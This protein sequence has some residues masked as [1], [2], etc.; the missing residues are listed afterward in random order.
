[1]VIGEII[2]TNISEA[3]KLNAELRSQKLTEVNNE[4]KKIED[5]S[6]EFTMIVNN[7]QENVLKL[8]NGLN[9]TVA[10]GT[11]DDK[12]KK[13][14]ELRSEF[15]TKV[16]NLQGDVTKLRND[17]M[18]TPV[19]KSK[20]DIPDDISNSN[21]KISKELENIKK[22][23]TRDKRAQIYTGNK[24]TRLRPNEYD[25]VEQ[26]FSYRNA[27]GKGSALSANIGDSG[28][29]NPNS[30]YTDTNEL[31]GTEE[32]NSRLRPNGGMEEVS[33]RLRPNEH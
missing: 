3:R 9:N 33:S 1:M 24:V 2:N 26:D 17:L 19:V 30:F 20:S 4:R 21:D 12:F 10:K 14:D 15:S 29:T 7:L 13:I 27:V 6:N 11:L 5:L 18:N 23:L 31:G 8:R 28:Y 16:N 22:V 32:V 25:F